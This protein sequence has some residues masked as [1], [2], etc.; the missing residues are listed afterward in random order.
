[1][2]DKSKVRHEHDLN[3][4][5]VCAGRA[6][7]QTNGN[8]KFSSFVCVCE[9]FFL[10]SILSLNSWIDLFEH[11]N[12]LLILV[13]FWFQ[14]FSLHRFVD[15][16]IR[17]MRT[18]P[19]WWTIFSSSIQKPTKQPI[20]DIF[21]FCCCLKKCSKTKTHSFRMQC[22]THT[23]TRARI[24]TFGTFIS[25]GEMHLNNIFLFIWWNVKFPRTQKPCDFII[26]IY[27]P[28]D[29]FDHKQSQNLQNSHKIK[30]NKERKNH[31]VMIMHQQTH[32]LI[33]F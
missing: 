15:K 26:Y 29:A 7:G 18:I 17:L 1:M 14:W 32:P 22:C 25:S 19:F 23:H 33:F 20:N 30:R 31:N 10:N 12:F 21:C 5:T 11:L 2:Y 8:I 9:C 24:H 13:F 6:C 28:V 3:N 16:R 27:R 4:D